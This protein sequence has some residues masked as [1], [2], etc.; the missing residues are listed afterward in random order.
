MY[1][2][3]ALSR[4]VRR[5]NSQSNFRSSPYQLLAPR[6]LLASDLGSSTWTVGYDP[7]TGIETVYQNEELSSLVNQ[8]RG[9]EGKGIQTRGPDRNVIS[10]GDSRTVH[11]DDDRIL[12]TNTVGFPWSTI[13]KLNTTFPNGVTSGCSGAVIDSYHVLTAG[14]CIHNADRGG[15]ADEVL[16]S[17]GKD[18]DAFPFGTARATYQRTYTAWT[19][20]QDWNHD[21]ALLTLDRSI[22]VF[23]GH[24][25][26][27]VLSSSSFDNGVL[28]NT[29]GYPGD[30]DFG[31]RMYRAVGTTDSSTDTKVF[32][33]GHDGLDTFNGQSGS[34]LWRLDPSDGERYI[35]TIHTNGEVPAYPDLNS[36]A[37]LNTDKFNRL[38][39]WISED[40]SARPPVERPDLIDYDDA[41]NTDL[42]NISTSF[43]APGEVLDVQTFVRNNGT[44]TASNYEV[45]FYIST[46]NTIT[47]SDTF[48]GSQAISSTAPF[49]WT[50]A[51]IST[52][53]PTLSPGDYYVGWVIDSGNSV[54]EYSEDNNTGYVTQLLTIDDHGNDASLATN[55]AL[56]FNAS[57]DIQRGTESDWFRFRAVAG[58]QYDFE[59]TLGSLSDTTLRLIGPDGTTQLAFDDDGGNGRAS[60]ISWTAENDDTYFIVVDSF[61]SNTGTY[62]L[63]GSYIDDFGNDAA[64]SFFMSVPQSGIA[65]TIEGGSDEDWFSFEATEGV[66][67]EFDTDAG[68]LTDTTL[69]LYDLDGTTVLDFNDD[70]GSDLTSRIN[71]LA[72]QDGTYYLAVGSF[73]SNIGSYLLNA[74]DS[75]TLHDISVND[76]QS[77]RSTVDHLVLT[78]SGSVDID[79]DAFSLI[80]RSDGDGNATGFAVASSFTCT[81]GNDTVVTLTFGS[82]TRNGAGALADGNYQLTVDGSKVRRAGTNL[83]LGADFVYGDSSDEPFYTLYGDTNGDRLVNVFDLLGFRRAYLT[84]EGDADFDS[85]LDFNA[86]DVIN[87]FD[88]LSFRQNYRKSLPF[89]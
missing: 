12:V 87:V 79:P 24:M 13:T 89:V 60:L 16:V 41:L 27:E 22:G 86:D 8:I 71:W 15:F 48:L 1:I 49:Q 70:D 76:G 65:G 55:V 78:F 54:P 82:Q 17:P 21:W 35:N 84:A 59:T 88:L 53:I 3:K 56:P 85:D 2:F 52:V 29:A 46:N 50:A 23:T 14:H 83:T 68:S 57:G 4:L 18:G 36:G 42:S 31:Q 47:D 43:G 44:A 33:S 5:R 63:T 19:Q 10:S 20:N 62:E 58:V 9:I 80:Q 39:T 69:S 7:S 75:P 6:V 28:L 67:Y 34:P 30:L 64:S 40:A 25:G 77:Q 11:G 73:S 51:E 26:R 61:S 66:S 32:Y 38:S 74:N 81:K 37:R 45:K 72:P